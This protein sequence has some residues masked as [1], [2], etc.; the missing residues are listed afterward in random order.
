MKQIKQS[1][2]QWTL[3]YQSTE[4]SETQWLCVDV[5]GHKIINVYKPPSSRLTPTAIPTF[6]HP[7][8]YAAVSL[9]RGDFWRLTPQTKLQAPQIQLWSII[10]RWSFY[11]IWECQDPWTN[12]PYWKLSGNGS[13]RWRLQLSARQ[14]GLQYEYNISTRCFQ[15]M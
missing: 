4:Q 14:L 2:N 12:P 5:A 8:L 3:V 7:S 10:Y 1:I 13:V 15:K 9:P 6:P 11:K